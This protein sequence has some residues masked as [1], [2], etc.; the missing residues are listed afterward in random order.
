MP[1]PPTAALYRE[2]RVYPGTC[3][4]R[5]SA[6]MPA[7]AWRRDGCARTRRRGRRRIDGRRACLRV[8]TSKGDV[9]RRRARPRDALPAQPAHEH[10]KQPD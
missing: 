5:L 7:P 2:S 8:R 9:Q 3:T 6:R 4:C 10:K 1:A